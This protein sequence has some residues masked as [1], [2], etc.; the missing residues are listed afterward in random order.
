[1]TRINII[2]IMII[3]DINTFI[4]TRIIV[5]ALKIKH[6]HGFYVSII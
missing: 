3:T 5:T 1:M 6:L 2:I 4:S